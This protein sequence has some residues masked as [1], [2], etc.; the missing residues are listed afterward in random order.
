MLVGSVSFAV[1]L[2][3]LLL[4]GP[5]VGLGLGVLTFFAFRAAV[6]RR[7]QR[8]RALFA[9]QLGDTLQ[10]LA[11]NLRA[12]HGL[13]QSVDTVADE[14]D[15]PTR[16]EFRRVVIETRLGHNLADALHA[17]AAR[18]CRGRRSG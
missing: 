9:D 5:F 15:S 16:E 10:L 2:F 6:T 4:F 7:A 14:S 13:L 12:G 8:R 11:G 1:L 17:A 3:G 18:A